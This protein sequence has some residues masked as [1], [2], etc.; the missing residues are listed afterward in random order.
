MAKYVLIENELY[1][2]KTG[3]KKKKHRKIHCDYW[4]ITTK[5]GEPLPYT[6]RVIN[7]ESLTS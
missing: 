6:K 3:N 7:T 5:S 4:A 2:K 1:N